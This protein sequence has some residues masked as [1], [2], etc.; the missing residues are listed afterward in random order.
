MGEGILQLW[1]W[2]RY[3]PEVPVGFDGLHFAAQNVRPG[4]R[5]ARRQEEAFLRSVPNVLTELGVPPGL[6][7]LTLRL[8]LLEI[9]ARYVDALT[10]GA[11]AALRRRTTWVL[12]LLER[13]SEHPNPASSEGRP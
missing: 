1:D 3:D 8:Y 4:E 11:T 13:L 5:A 12:S 6:H 9:A 7:D 10:H 2:E